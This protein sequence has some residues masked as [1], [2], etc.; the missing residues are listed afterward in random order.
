MEKEDLPGPVILDVE[1]ISCSM[2]IARNQDQKLQLH[3][4]L[5]MR[6]RVLDEVRKPDESKLSTAVWTLTLYENGSG[7]E[8][9]KLHDAVGL[10]NYYEAWESSDMES[11]ESCHAWVNV[12]GDTFAVLR[13]MALA[14]KLPDRMR[15]HTYGMNYGWEPD[16][17]GKVWDVKAHK[18]AP[19]SEVNFD[20]TLIK[21]PDLVWDEE[22]GGAVALQP[23]GDSPELVAA[24]GMVKAI[25]QVS[26]QLSW[27][28]G[29]LAL[30][31][32]VLIFR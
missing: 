16:G 8:L 7:N 21:G 10:I 1:P 11:P 6:L 22:E 28:I 17:T 20:S 30:A 15:L 29:L 23:P 27:V 13:G 24:R 3:D 14:G 4:S 31:V 2:S 9:T 19:I 5:T 26:T 18:N 12:D 25:Q 32:A